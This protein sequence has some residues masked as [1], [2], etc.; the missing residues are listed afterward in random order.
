MRRGT[1][2]LLAALVTAATPGTSARAALE[3]PAY[4]VITITNDGL[5]AVP[6]W[7]YDSE[8]WSCRTEIL[9]PYLAP[10]EVAVSCT[11]AQGLRF[12]CPLMVLTVQ[13]RGAGAR[14]GGHASCTYTLDTGVLH[15]VATARLS[16][17]L[18][19]VRVLRCSAYSVDVPLVPPYTVT[20]GEPGLP[21][22][23]AP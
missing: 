13:T 17:N 6:V 11:P 9:G 22:V 12:A 10:R 20:C 23:A 7:T 21:T 5:G 1:T 14:A 3:V 15:G 8:L 19:P 16:G 4:G 2:L 18:G